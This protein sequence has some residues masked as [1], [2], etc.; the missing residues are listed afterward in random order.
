MAKNAK[1]KKWSKWKITLLRKLNWGTFY[2]VLNGR[3]PVFDRGKDAR[4]QCTKCKFSSVNKGNVRQ[5]WKEVHHTG[6]KIFKC[7][8]CELQ[9]KQEG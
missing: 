1:K 4:F 8:K 3:I 2:E 6:N 7:Q 5:H 9:K